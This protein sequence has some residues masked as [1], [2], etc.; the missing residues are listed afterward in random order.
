ML[1]LLIN[2]CVHHGTSHLHL[3]VKQDEENTT[4]LIVNRITVYNIFKMWLHNIF[5]YLLFQL[6]LF[7]KS[8]KAY[9]HEMVYDGI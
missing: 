1:Y 8:K 4:V 2:G 6:S 9:K 3:F 7:H 5:I